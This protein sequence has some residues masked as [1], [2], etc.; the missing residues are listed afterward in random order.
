MKEDWDH[1]IRF[2]RARLNEIEKEGREGCL[3]GVF[4]PGRDLLL[5]SARSLVKA[6]EITHHMDGIPLP[7][8]DAFHRGGGDA[9]RNQLFFLALNWNT[10]PDFGHFWKDDADA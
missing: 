6:F 2:V 8:L 7:P 10:H 5:A 9:L 1:L 4:D 3:E